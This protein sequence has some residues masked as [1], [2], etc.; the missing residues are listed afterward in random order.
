MV[1]SWTSTNTTVFYPFDFNNIPVVQAN[2]QSTASA[3]G[4]ERSPANVTKTKFDVYTNG[5]VSWI[6]TGT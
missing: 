5:P 4:Y 1:T 3:N 6:A 2:T